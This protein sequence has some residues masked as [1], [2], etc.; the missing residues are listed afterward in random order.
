MVSTPSTSVQFASSVTANED[1][2]VDEEMTS[3][4]RESYSCDQCSKSFVHFR[5]LS[6][7]KRTHDKKF[8]CNECTAEFI[9]LANL[10]LHKKVHKLKLECNVCGKNVFNREADFKKHL[11]IH[12]GVKEKCLCGKEFSSV[13][14]LRRHRKKCF[15]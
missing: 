7:H 5:N 4:Q 15:K 10:S 3:V 13:D 14:S 8:K 2:S 11:K 9:N 1:A 6:S 12:S